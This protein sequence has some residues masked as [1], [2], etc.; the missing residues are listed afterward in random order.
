M[1]EVEG[2]RTDVRVVVLSYYATDWY[3]DQ[4]TVKMNDSEPFPYSLTIDNYRQGT[5]DVLYIQELPQ[6]ADQS[7]DLKEYMNVVKG[8]FRSSKENLAQIK[9]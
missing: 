5:N 6:F 3:I 4:T 7:I 8:T 1:Q 9:N 2:F